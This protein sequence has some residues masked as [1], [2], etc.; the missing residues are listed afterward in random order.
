MKDPYEVLIPL[1]NPNEPEAQVTALHVSEGQ[2]VGKGDTLC[3]LETTKSSQD[4]IV[5]QAGYVV[6]LHASVGNV[7]RAGER[8]C[9]LA[10]SKGWKPPQPAVA[11][12]VEGVELPEGLRITEPALK[13]AQ[14]AELDL[15]SLPRG[16][17]ITR[18]ML[19]RVPREV[20]AREFKIPKKKYSENSLVVYGGGGHGKTLIELIRAVGDYTIAGVI[21]DGL[22][23]GSEV[24][25][26]VIFGGGEAITAI[27]ER[28]VRMAVNAVGG[29]GDITSRI[30]VFERISRAGLT[31]P[32]LIHPSAVVEE[33]SRLAEGVQV[34]SHGYIGSDAQIGFGVIVNTQAVVSHDCHVGDYANIAPGALLAGGV[35][36]GESALVGMGV[37][38]NLNVTIG[39]GARVGNSAVV[40]QDVPEGTIVR[41]GSIWP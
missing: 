29:I 3:T 2:K 27:A 32:T 6:G 1:L 35:S 10:D 30:A 19:K 15:T 13:F 37:T 39:P 24:M 38:I 33:S 31:C 17:L 11:E 26:C 21:D 41:A 25:G 34:F 5:E 28:G 16:P 12:T 18:A 14:D 40:K 36:I 4:V 20:G 8:L 7:L 23:V 22:D 9:W